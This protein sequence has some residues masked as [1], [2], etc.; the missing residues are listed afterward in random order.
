MQTQQLDVHEQPSDDV[1]LADAA[2][3]RLRQ[4]SMK[5]AM[6]QLNIEV[7]DAMQPLEDDW[8]ALERD[9]HQSLHQSYDWCAAW[10]SAFQRP[11]AI[12]KATHAGQTVF[13]LP[14][15]IV[16]SRGLRTARFIAADHSN[17]N[18]GLFA[19]SF[20]EAG[21][22]IAPMSSPA[23]SG[24]RCRAAPICC[25]CRTFRWNGAGE[26]ARSPGC[27]WCRTRITPISCR[28]FPLSRTR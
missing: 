28:S 1:A 13:I 6:A 12:V 8:R 14:V 4:L 16:K 15:E 25:C 23:S 2:I 18:T 10:V 21:R 20:A 7:F 19:E 17:I 5:L 24:M 26:K 3:S 27:R 9:N 11:L 22:T